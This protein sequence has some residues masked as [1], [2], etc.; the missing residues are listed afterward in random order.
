MRNIYYL[1]ILL[2]FSNCRSDKIDII[3]EKI[4]LP[5][6][7]TLLINDIAKYIDTISFIELEESDESLLSE[8]S[9]MLIDKSGNLYTLGSAAIYVFKPD[10]T[11]LRSISGKGRGPREF[12]NVCDFCIS[13]NGAELMIL[14]ENK[15]LCFGITDTTFFQEIPISLNFPI[16]AISPTEN[17]DVYLFSAFPI[18]YKEGVTENNWLLTKINRKGELLGQYLE[19][20]DWTFTNIAITQVSNNRY[21]LRPQNS[22][23]IVYE[24]TS[25]LRPL[26]KIDFKAE[27]IPAQ[28]QYDGI[29]RNVQDFFMA[30]YYKFPS[31]FQET[32]DY[33]FF[34]V[35]ADQAKE[36]NFIYSLEQIKGINWPSNPDDPFVSVIASDSEYFYAVIF[37]ADIEVYD[38]ENPSK[39]GPLFRFIAESMIALEPINNSNPIIVKF[40][41]TI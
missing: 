19:K 41:L 29:G 39:H 21:Y 37:S 17:G 28:Y 6:E 24:L 9:N 31:Y 14:D 35:A 7:Q 33:L 23:H 5:L 2:C 15:I 20:D 4:L 11:F 13:K 32:N 34:K 12:L 10:G 26:Y 38:A 22:K 16:D 25:D 8:I 27:G 18:N 30:P 3:A 36:Y 40:K 1:I